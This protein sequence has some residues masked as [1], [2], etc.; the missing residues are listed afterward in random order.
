MCMC[1]VCVFVQVH[2]SM[3]K[4]GITIRISSSLASLLYFCRAQRLS[5]GLELAIFARLGP[6][7]YLSLLPNLQPQLW[8]CSCFH[9]GAGNPN[10]G[11]DTSM[12][13]FYSCIDLFSLSCS[14]Y[15]EA[16]FSV[17]QNRTTIIQVNK[18]WNQKGVVI[19]PELSLCWEMDMDQMVRVL[20]MSTV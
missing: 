14:F 19:Y 11:P 13:V 3:Q 5:L 15:V 6:R 7:I 16:S 18:Y 20:S 10:S 8:G 12:K 9:L 4:P 2:W 1:A 17:W